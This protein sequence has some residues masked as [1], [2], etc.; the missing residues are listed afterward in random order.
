MARGEMVVLLSTTIAGS[1]A[2]IRLRDAASPPAGRPLAGTDCAAPAGSGPG[3]AQIRP[4][5]IFGDLECQSIGATVAEDVAF[6]PENLG[7]PPEEIR[8]RVESALRTVS[9]EDFGD[10]AVRSLPASGRFRLALAGALALEP[11]A[12]LVE[13]AT[14]ALDGADR[15]EAVALL[16]SLAGTRGIPVVLATDDSGLAEAADRL[17]V[18][19]GGKI[20]LDGA[21]AQVPPLLPPA[22]PPAASL[23]DAATTPAS[24]SGV[25]LWTEMTA[26]PYIPGDSL[27]HRCDPRTKTALALLFMS[28]A[29]LMHGLAAQFLLLSV[30]LAAAARAGRPL[31]RSLRG[32]RPILYLAGATVTAKLILAGGAPLAESGALSHVSREALAQSATLLVRLFVF[33]GAAS[34]LTLT[35]TP[36]ALAEGVERLMRPLARLGVPVSEISMMLLIAVKFLPLILEEA[37]GIIRSGARV[38]APGA[39]RG[40]AR[41]AHA[42]LALIVP[43]F[44]AVARRGDALALAME[45]RCYRAGAQRTRMSRSGFSGAD[46]ACAAL[47]L[48]TLF[49]AAAAE[50]TGTGMKPAPLVAQHLVSGVR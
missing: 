34:L 35:T 31:G 1:C 4:G 33:A 8:A 42:A 32:L 36:V 26:Q 17:V 25:K 29:S 27:L 43:L 47:L 13:H 48:V 20:V 18:L 46:A 23:H 30:T 45:A 3:Q 40:L 50:R 41:R 10:H 2:C 9:L 28:A 7:L 5:T 38:C 16:R 19:K 39:G 11:D 22:P 44:S 49:L 21:P 6:G 12:L 37:Q 24:P 14:D 15:G